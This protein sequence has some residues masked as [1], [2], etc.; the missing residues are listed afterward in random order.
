MERDFRV[1]VW[2]LTQLSSQ[3]QTSGIVAK[4]PVDYRRDS[5]HVPVGR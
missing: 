3:K 1:T 4:G 5:G 2:T